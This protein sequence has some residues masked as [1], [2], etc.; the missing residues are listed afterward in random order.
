MA[1]CAAAAF[2]LSQIVLGFEAVRRRLFGARISASARNDAVLWTPGVATPVR[3]PRPQRAH[4]LIVAA[5]VAEAVFVA[6]TAAAWT[7]YRAPADVGDRDLWSLAM[8]SI[9]SSEPVADS[10]DRLNNWIEGNAK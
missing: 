5:L 4:K 7:S 8:Q 10:R 6:G 1:C 9:C 2:F 3:S